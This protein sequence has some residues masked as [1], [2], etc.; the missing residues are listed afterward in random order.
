M[1]PNLSDRSV[2]WL[3]WVF[4]WRRVCCHGDC[5]QVRTVSHD[6]SQLRRLLYTVKALVTNRF[7]FLQP[8]PYVRCTFTSLICPF[9]FN[10]S[11][12]GWQISKSQIGLP[13]W[14]RLTRVVREK[15]PL[16]RCVCVGVG[17]NRLGSRVVSVLDSRA[18]APWFKS[19]PRR[20]R[21]TVLGELFTLIV[22]LFTKQRH[23]YQTS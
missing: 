1:Q 9:C 6:M 15:G 18:E 8:K 12:I 21:V 2:P 23:W 13:F 3:V 14:Y 4:P 11:L 10:S 17:G 19:Q 7:L 16:N 22:P 5:C 20:C